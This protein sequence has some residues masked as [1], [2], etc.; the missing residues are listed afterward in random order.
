MEGKIYSKPPESTLQGKTNVRALKTIHE[1]KEN[2][3]LYMEEKRKHGSKKTHK[4]GGV[5]KRGM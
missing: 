3:G 1:S 5:N 4:L 2:V